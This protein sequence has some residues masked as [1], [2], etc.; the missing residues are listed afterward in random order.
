MKIEE[1]IKKL[2]LYNQEIEVKIMCWSEL[3]DKIVL[4]E[5]DEL[6]V[7]SEDPKCFYLSHRHEN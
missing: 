2:E 1:L 5:I 6:G 4:E 3:S 7:T